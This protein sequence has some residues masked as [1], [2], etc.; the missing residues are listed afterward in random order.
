MDSAKVFNL[1]KKKKKKMERKERNFDS[2]EEYWFL[3][4]VQYLKE[5]LH[6]SAPRLPTGKSSALGVLLFYSNA[7][8]FAKFRHES[9]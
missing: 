6:E 5:L 9:H 2:D 7:M 3:V 1:K 4:N 8:R